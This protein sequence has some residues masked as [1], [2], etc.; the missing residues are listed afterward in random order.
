MDSAVV[1]SSISK[2]PVPSRK[3][4][5]KKKDQ[6]SPLLINIDVNPSVLITYC[7]RSN[8]TSFNIQ[9]GWLKK[10]LS[11]LEHSCESQFDINGRE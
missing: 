1:H 2:R 5:K 9:M 7:I 6:S 3:E 8:V 4:K 10:V 11:M